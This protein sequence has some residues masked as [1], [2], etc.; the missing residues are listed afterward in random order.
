MARYCCWPG[1]PGWAGSR[2][3]IPRITAASWRWR[4]DARAELAPPGQ[5]RLPHRGGSGA[6]ARVQVGHWSASR[7]PALCIPVFIATRCKPTGFG[8]A[9]GRCGYLGEKKITIKNN[10]MLKDVQTLHA[11]G[12][13]VRCNRAA[14]ML[15]EPQLSPN[16]APKTWI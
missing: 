4:R 16:V 3:A 15:A 7:G 9:E 6:V 12:T 14:L 13:P 5:T 2:R 10:F 1:P 8:C 11:R